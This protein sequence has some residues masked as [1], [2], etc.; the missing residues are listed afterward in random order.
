MIQKTT[1]QGET[2]QQQILTHS[3]MS[4]F[5]DCPRKHF[6][7]YELGLTPDID[8][9]A[10]RFGSAIHEA[11]EG[12]DKGDAEMVAGAFAAI[13]DDHERAAARTLF[14]AHC[15]HYEYDG[16]TPVYSELPFDI[17]L[18]NPQT[19]MPS[20]NWR[21]NGKIDGIVQLADGR[22]ALLER[23]TTTRD[24]T[25]GSD[26]WTK[27]R[28]DA[29]IS[30][31]IIAARELGIQID[32]V[33]YD[34]MRRPS[35]RPYRATPEEKRK[36]KKDG[37]LY[38]SC[39]A[40]DETPE[41][42]ANRIGDDIHSRPEH[43]FTRQEIARL[44]QDLDE[45][46]ADLWQQQMAIRNAQLAGHWWRNPNACFGMFKCDYLPICQNNDLEYSTPAGFIRS[47]EIHPELSVEATTEG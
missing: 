34:V 6:I 7:R 40:E 16:V 31:Y 32:T 27:L 14:D 29:Q 11:L 33:L 21:L 13:E 46:H 20:R 19:G 39:R 37:T 38:A 24:F 5:R 43:Y 17:P 28:L 42:Y 3:R 9:D 2:A 41:E 1:T 15:A 44:E 35:L 12:W 25:P 23:K 22:L 30:I 18:T 36:Y 4:C 8:S 45:C 26:Y 47:E 10:R